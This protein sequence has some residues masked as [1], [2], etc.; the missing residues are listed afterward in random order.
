MAHNGNRY[1]EEFKRQWSYVHKV[2][3]RPDE[4]V[5]LGGDVTKWQRGLMSVYTNEILVTVVH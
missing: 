3:I 5:S 4:L 2:D 1:S